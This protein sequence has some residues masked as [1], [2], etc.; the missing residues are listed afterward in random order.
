MGCCLSSV[1][2]DAPRYADLE[3]EIGAANRRCWIVN[4][5]VELEDILESGAV[6]LVKVGYLIELS[7]S[8]GI[9]QR[10][11]LLPPQAFVSTTELKAATNQ[12]ELPIIVLS[13]PWLHPAHPDPKGENL[14]RI[15]RALKAHTRNGELKYGVFIDFISLFQHPDPANGLMRTEDESRLFTEGLSGLSAL[16]SHPWTTVFRLT[17][18]PDGYPAGYDMP[19]SCNVAEY[20]ERGWCFTETCWASLTKDSANSLDLGLF[21]GTNMASLNERLGMIDECRMGGR[22]PP[23]LPDQ[24]EAEIA[25][26]RFTNGKDDRPLVTR[27]YREAFEAQFKMAPRILN[28]HS[29]GWGDAEAAQIARLISSGAL[30]ESSVEM[31]SLGGNQITDAGVA[32]L[33]EALSQARWRKKFTLMLTNNRISDEGGAAIAAVA[34]QANFNLRLDGWDVDCMKMEDQDG[35]SVV[36]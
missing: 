12:Y 18:A 17:T 32:P 11:Q 8:R 3:D 33:C 34:K 26:K 20:H 16:Y 7:E 29:V 4:G 13:Y 31:I 21:T 2:E 36:V 30:H 19:A 15:G 10:R 27:L 9:L 6:G 35:V 24:F 1:E 28:Y 23:L 14:V 5:G 25:T 22:R